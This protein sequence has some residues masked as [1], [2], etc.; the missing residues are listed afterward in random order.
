LTYRIQVTLDDREHMLRGQVAIEYTNRSDTSLDEL[1]V[2]IWPNAYQQDGSGLAKEIYGNQNPV[3]ALARPEQRGFMDSLDFRCDGQDVQW[4]FFSGET[5]IIR[6]KLARPLSPGSK[7]TLATPFRV[8]LPDAAISRLGH[9]NGRYYLT[10]WYP[11]P[12]VYDRNGWNTLS[13]QNWGEF[14]GEYARYE[15]DIT[16][17]E[18]YWVAATGVLQDAAEYSRRLQAD[19]ITRAGGV[20][21][22]AGL[23]PTTTGAGMTLHFVA[24]SVHDFAL[25][26]AKDFQV[27]ADRV[28]G[29][30]EI[31]SFFLQQHVQQ[32]TLA[33]F[34]LRQ[35]L[36]SLSSWIGPYPYA[37]LIAVDVDDIAG[38]DMEYPMILAIGACGN[39]QFL[40]TL[41]HEA[42]HQWFYGMIGSN[43]RRHPWMD[44]GWTSYLENRLYL[45]TQRLVGSP[46]ESMFTR[47]L[48]LS[49]EPENFLPHLRL[50]YLKAA[51]RNTDP[52]TGESA[53]Y[54]NEDDYFVST[55]SKPTL[56]IVWLEDALGRDV[57]D[58]SMRAYYREWAFRHPQPADLQTVFERVS[59][60]SL[61]WYFNDW[62]N[63]HAKADYSIK[64]RNTPSRGA[65]ITVGNRGSVSG[66][67]T[68]AAFR[69]NQ[70]LEQ[71]TIS[72]RDFG[73]AFEWNVA[74]AE[75]FVLDP[76]HRVPEVNRRNNFSRAHGALRKAEPIR[77][78]FF[79]GHEVDLR[80]TVGL[81]PVVGWNTNNG[82]LIGGGLHN[83][84]FEEKPFEVLAMPLY[85]TQDKEMNFGGF[86]RY[87]FYP[88]TGNLRRIRLQSGWS[89][90]AYATDSYQDTSGRMLA[91]GALH[92][93]KADHS[94]QLKFM[95]GSRQKVESQ[96]RFNAIQIRKDLPYA[97]NYSAATRDDFFL[98]GA[99]ERITAFPDA[100]HLVFE[101][102]WH[103]DMY[104]F[105]LTEQL[106]LP[107]RNPKKGLRLRLFGGYVAINNTS[108]AGQDFRLR[109]SG[110]G[111]GDDYLFR[112]VFPGRNE[113]DGVF[114]HQFVLTEGGFTTP[115]SYFGKSSGWMLTA[116]AS[117]T[118]P[119]KL[120][121]RLYLAGGS[122][123]DINDFRPEFG[124]V[125]FE[126]GVELPILG[127]IFVVYLPA[128]YSKDVR[129]A[130][131]RLDLNTAETIRFELRFRELNPIELARKYLQ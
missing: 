121:F 71:R 102:Q 83:L 60:Q 40:Q 32:W 75:R 77:L 85:G 115:V 86:V 120:P 65:R 10:Q 63:T 45:N 124:K 87:H 38:R 41:Y 81:F 34:V 15:V 106:L 109:L 69:N 3:F 67:V 46:N 129:D 8:K 98:V 103:S 104:K 16:L 125:S 9:A 20:V 21:A 99:Y 126:G 118:L 68:L 50:N 59:G 107:Y 49:E 80:T 14:Y 128:V 2:H 6:I 27:L 54:Y 97:F 22:T 127:D 82:V 13:Y 24:D 79:I 51:S 131:D 64:V 28:P 57:F 43:E 93:R 113:P 114:S 19:S 30:P 29:K 36:N 25:F 35:S 62:T 5:D 117:T 88:K 52:L 122:F 91:D 47:W 23:R 70:L 105:T 89:R 61:D 44:E 42:A 92:Y 53:L 7:T 108:V 72:S 78:Q 37:H 1:Y 76:D 11:K 12:A 4:T 90:Y 119:G 74:D 66:P 31:W 110:F 73:Q 26:A 94:L 112:D 48:R 123:E 95:H 101:A 55:Y 58:Q 39:R 130:L 17:P 100:S 84:N 111:G 96:L 56:G 18:S 33:N 116:R